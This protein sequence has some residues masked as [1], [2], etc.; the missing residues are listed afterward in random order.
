M[1]IDHIY[2]DGDLLLMALPDEFLKILRRP[3]FGF[4]RE[5]LDR[6]VASIVVR[7]ST[8]GEEGILSDREHFHRVD[9]ETSAS[10]HDRTAW[11]GG[12]A[13]QCK[14]SE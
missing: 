14:S 6:I 12:A 2:N 7:G 13:S 9:A 1:V 11:A 10:A 3:V 4:D 5:E 8:I